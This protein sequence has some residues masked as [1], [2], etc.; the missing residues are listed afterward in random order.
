[1]KR[2]FIL[3]LVALAFA[4]SRERTPLPQNHFIPGLAIPLRLDKDQ[5]QIFLADLVPDISIIDSVYLDGKKVNLQEDKNNITFKTPADANPL[6]EMKIWSKGSYQSV[7]VMKS[8]KVDYLYSFDPAN[9]DSVDNNVGGINSV[10]K[11]GLTDKPALPIILLPNMKM[12]K[13]NLMLNGPKRQA[14]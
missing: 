1:M 4:C 13:V 6:M 11:V 7:L 2:I 8:R 12:Q 9:P 10:M 14:S 3:C 5:S